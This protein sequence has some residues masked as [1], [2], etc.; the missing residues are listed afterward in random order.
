MPLQVDR[1]CRMFFLPGIQFIKK[2]RT[3]R[4]RNEAGFELVLLDYAI[5]VRSSG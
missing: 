1:I 4:R 2:R 5:L 3:W